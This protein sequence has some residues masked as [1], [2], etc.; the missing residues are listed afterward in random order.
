[1]RFQGERIAATRA[2]R[3]AVVMSLCMLL[4]H[5]NQHALGADEPA[6]LQASLTFCERHHADGE[7][8]ETIQQR[9]MELAGS[10]C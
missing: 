2:A 5:E 1:M 10:P 9:L 4:H 3:L 8:I 6:A 7:L